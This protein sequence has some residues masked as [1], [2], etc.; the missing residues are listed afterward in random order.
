[1]FHRLYI[2]YHQYVA[3][4]TD[5]LTAA[6]LFVNVAKP[7][8]QKRKTGVCHEPL[9]FKLLMSVNAFTEPQKKKAKKADKF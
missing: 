9:R 8:Q 4:V 6:M 2:S 3:N 1:M 5:R 7:L